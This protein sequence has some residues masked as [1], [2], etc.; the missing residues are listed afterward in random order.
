VSDTVFPEHMQARWLEHDWRFIHDEP[1]HPRLQ[2]AIDEVLTNEVAAGRRAPTL[3]IWEW[4][5][6]AVILGRFQSVRNE[7]DMEGARRHDVTVC[8][9][10]TGGG[11][12]FVEPQNTITYSI[13]APESLVK[14]LSFVDS[15]A[16]MDQWVLEALRGL[17]VNAVYKPIND[18]SS[19]KGKIGGAAQT[20][21]NGAVL[22]H[23]TMAYDMDAAKMLEV[24]RIG[25]EKL[26]DKGSVSAN[27]RVTPLREQTALPRQTIIEALASTFD[28]KF[29]LTTSRLSPEELAAA[30]TL[31][32]EKFDTDEWLYTLP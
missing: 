9:R 10:I 29:G 30:E 17:G 15:Y 4:T 11:A 3:R 16:F 12:M 25:R 20:R 1:T 21:R 13:Y 24:L 19:D 6:N 26:S 32:R 8:R 31:R 7:V 27:K 2:M 22:H 18:I 23:V 28:R 14:G 5:S